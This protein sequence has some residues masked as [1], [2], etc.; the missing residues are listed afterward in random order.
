LILVKVWG[1]YPDERGVWMRTPWGKYCSCHCVGDVAVE[2]KQD[3]A[4]M[5]FA[6]PRSCADLQA[7]R[8]VVILISA[9][10]LQAV[11]P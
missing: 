3:N 9:G 11:Q 6:A 5:K 1:E 4:R 2:D 8:L 10:S 7:A